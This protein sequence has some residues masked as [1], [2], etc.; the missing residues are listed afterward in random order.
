MCLG[1]RQ[2][3]NQSKRRSRFVE[4]SGP[5]FKSQKGRFFSPNS[6]AH[7]IKRIY[8][9]AG[10]RN[11]SSHSGR[12]KFATTLIEQGADINCVK[13]LMGHSSIQTTA[14][15]FSPS[16]KRLPNLMS[17]L[18]IW[19]EI[20]LEISLVN[21]GIEYTD[22]RGNGDGVDLGSYRLRKFVA[23]MLCRQARWMN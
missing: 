10:F 17:S 3:S 11:A 9:D 18:Q 7:L 16:P 13:L 22:S 12:K 4:P 8:D 5:L 6:M 15:Y 20:M 2:I 14:L 23:A 21:D 19:L 1:D